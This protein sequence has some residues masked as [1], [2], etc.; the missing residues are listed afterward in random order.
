MCIGTFRVHFRP[1]RSSFRHASNYPPTCFF[2]CF[3]LGSCEQTYYVDYNYVCWGFS[4]FAWDSCCS[5]S[6]VSQ[7]RANYSG[8][9]VPN[10]N[11]NSR[12]QFRLPGKLLLSRGWYATGY[13]CVGEWPIFHYYHAR[14]ALFNLS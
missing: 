6:L 14:S 2:I 5:V 4:P 11:C 8:S 7:N 1:A 9:K 10:S 3:G 12:S 13:H